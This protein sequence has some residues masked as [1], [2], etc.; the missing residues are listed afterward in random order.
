MR[1]WTNRLLEA[2]EEGVLSYEAVAKA[3]LVFM[4]ENEVKKMCHNEE[5]FP[6]DWDAETADYNDVGSVHHY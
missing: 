2:L 5:F 3:A 1:E 4:S 6:E